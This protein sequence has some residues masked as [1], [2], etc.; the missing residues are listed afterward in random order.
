M[1]R[2][3]GGVS[4]PILFWGCFY[5]KTEK[6]KRC[7]KVKISRPTCHYHEIPQRDTPPVE[8]QSVVR[9]CGKVK[10]SMHV[11]VYMYRYW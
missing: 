5:W 2:D 1:N 4:P 3:T 6:G 8:P 11:A 9:V 7:G 10:I